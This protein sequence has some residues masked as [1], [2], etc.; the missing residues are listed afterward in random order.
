VLKGPKKQAGGRRRTSKCFGESIS[1]D[2]RVFHSHE[3]VEEAENLRGVGILFG[4]KP[5]SSYFKAS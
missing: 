5:L 2:R 3:G 1:Q 4:E